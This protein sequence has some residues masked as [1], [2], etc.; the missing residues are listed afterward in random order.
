[1][2]ILLRS[3]STQGRP[4]L[5]MLVSMA[6]AGITA[7]A[8][9]APD[10]QTLLKQSDRAR[11]GGLPGI[12]WTVTADSREGGRDLES[13]V[14]EVKA[15]ADASLAETQKPARFRG[16]K[17]LQVGRNMW[18]TK[19]GLSKPI[20]VSPRQRMTG[21]AS[22]GDIAATDYA[23]D[24]NGVLQGEEAIN[25]EACYLL[26]LTARDRGA[27]YDHI[28]YWIAKDRGVGVKAEF[29]S[30]SGKLLKVATFEYKQTIIY[31]GQSI[32]FIS[33]MTITDALQDAR[34]DLQYGGVVVQSIPA[35][36][37]AQGQ[38]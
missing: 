37:F 26:D 10:A 12:V 23:G 31:Q 16:N 11:G 35:S 8:A 3:F 32:P 15:T 13:Q 9:A 4:W 36:E 7:T 29:Y 18:V 34:T 25:G 24:Y 22:N 5:A 2:N 6:M 33:H 28:R 1:M 19:P 20:P 21:L 17:L 38:L 14:L 27:T 30:L